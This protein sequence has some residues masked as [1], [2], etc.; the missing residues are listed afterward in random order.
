[1]HEE[2]ISLK[3][4]LLIYSPRSKDYTIASCIGPSA[5]KPTQPT[6]ENLYTVFTSTLNPIKKNEGAVKKKEKIKRKNSQEKRVGCRL[7]TLRR[8][9]RDRKYICQ[10]MQNL[11]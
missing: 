8:R 10:S 6:L 11:F 4:R 5:N 3:N 9:N 2:R 1:M 7:Y